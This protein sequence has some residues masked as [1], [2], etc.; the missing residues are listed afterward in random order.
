MK[1]FFYRWM[2]PCAVLACTLPLGAQP[3]SSLPGTLPQSQGYPTGGPPEGMS[4]PATIQQQGPGPSDR[5]V[6]PVRGSTGPVPGVYPGA[7]QNQNSS[8]SLRPLYTPQGI[9]H[10]LVNGV[11]YYP[12][13]LIEQK[14]GVK[15]QVDGEGVVWV[16]GY[17]TKMVPYYYQEQLFVPAAPT[18]DPRQYD[19]VKMNTMRKETTAAEAALKQQLSQID[20]K[21]GLAEAYINNP[22]FDVKVLPHPWLDPGSQ[23]LADIKSA[24]PGANKI[25]DH[26]ARGSSPAGPRYDLTHM[27]SGLANQ[28]SS[29]AKM[30]AQKAPV[31]KEI[32]LAWKFV[33][34]Q[35]QNAYYRVKAISLKT[36]PS[37]GEWKAGEDKVLVLTDIKQTNL[38]NVDL[39]AVGYF[40]LKDSDG[41]AY[42]PLNRVE[43]GLMPGRSRRGH[44]VFEVPRSVMLK[45]VDLEG[46][47]PLKI[48]VFEAR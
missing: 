18:L 30:R 44:W 6:A 29:Y 19:Y 2:V 42:R 13:S 12:A 16:N 47:F 1:K 5:V 39:E 3:S 33:A 35:G 17:E 36:L 46:T 28:Q 14:D 7:M 27:P 11:R 37:W 34:G 41:G 45:R 48:E 22:G 15:F 40:V 26:L 4:P 31:K 24:N 25:P 38:S 20:D 23:P 21:E 43:G 9:Y 8:S 10:I 32:P